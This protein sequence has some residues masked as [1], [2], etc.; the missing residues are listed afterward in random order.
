MKGHMRPLSLLEPIRKSQDKNLRHQLH[1]GKIKFI[2]KGKKLKGEYV[3]IK[4]HGRGENA[5]LLI[6]IKDENASKVDILSKDKSVMSGK[7]LE[8]IATTSTRIYGRSAKEFN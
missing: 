5:W 2:L 6:K 4:A 7:T 8:E 1:S 3:L